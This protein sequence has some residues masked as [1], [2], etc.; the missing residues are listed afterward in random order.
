[1][2]ILITRNR[3]IESFALG[4]TRIDHPKYVL[5]GCEEVKKNDSFFLLQIWEKIRRSEKWRNDLEMQFNEITWD[6][7]DPKKKCIPHRNH[8]T[9]TPTKKAKK[10][11]IYIQLVKIYFTKSDMTKV[12][13]TL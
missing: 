8:P 3:I 9:P 1:M 6:M 2:V 5:I 11:F 10:D 4:S 13:H 12:S 7:R